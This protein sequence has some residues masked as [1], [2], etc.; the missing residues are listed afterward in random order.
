MLTYEEA[1]VHRENHLD[2]HVI[3]NPD[4]EKKEVENWSS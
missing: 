1:L 3:I 4:F 2:H